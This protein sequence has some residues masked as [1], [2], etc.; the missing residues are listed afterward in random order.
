MLNACLTTWWSAMY[1]PLLTRYGFLN[2][3]RDIGAVLAWRLG[4]ELVEH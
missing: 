2:V 4:P 1:P 3:A